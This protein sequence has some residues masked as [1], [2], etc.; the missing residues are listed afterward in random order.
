MLNNICNSC[1][2]NQVAVYF[3]SPAS[4]LLFLSGLSLNRSEPKS[5]IKFFLVEFVTYTFFYKNQ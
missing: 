1:R 5:I 3:T 4:E 2:K